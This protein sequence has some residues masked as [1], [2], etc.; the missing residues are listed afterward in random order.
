MSDREEVLLES[1]FVLHHRPFRN[2]SMLLDCLT[3]D[4]GRVGLVAQGSRRPA[5]G[6]RALLQPF[7]PLRL[8]WVR[9]SELGRLTQVEAAGTPIPLAGDGLLAGFYVNEL[10]LRLVARGDSSSAVFSC[11]SQC[12]AGLADRSSVARNLRIFELGLLECLGY[13][14]ELWHDVRTGE[15]LQVDGR[16]SFELEGGPVAIAEGSHEES[17]TGAH[18][19]SL[20]DNTLDDKASLATAKRLLGRILGSY[21]GERP[22][23]TRAVLAEIIEG[24][25][26]L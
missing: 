12:L 17:Y 3:S 5:G 10:L 2:T 4:H 16:Y 7:A 11:Y 23:K 13:R 6:K 21:L 9:R 15:P 20:R 1:S 25:F 14:V 26:E 22:L 18:L 24:G 8:S 19:I